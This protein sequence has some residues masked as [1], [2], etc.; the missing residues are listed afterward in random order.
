MTEINN[1]EVKNEVAE[2]FDD[3]D[4]GDFEEASFSAAPPK[5]T[6]SIEEPDDPFPQSPRT[7]NQFGFAKFD[8]KP[9]KPQSSF[10]S[11]VS[12]NIFI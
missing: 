3:D 1:D 6:T 9:L 5:P 11:F 12:F 10:E 4:F 2:E 7:D 8:G